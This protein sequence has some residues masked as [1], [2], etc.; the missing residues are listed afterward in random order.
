MRI[1]SPEALANAL[2]QARKQ[3]NLTQAE[4]SALA[5]TKQTTVSALENTPDNSKIE[6]LFKLLSG[7]GL[8]ISIEPRNHAE[9]GMV[10]SGQ[11]WDQE[12]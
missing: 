12:W 8:E 5:G 6:T 9:S 2:R 4:L 3:Q 11:A 1:T 10:A 7:L